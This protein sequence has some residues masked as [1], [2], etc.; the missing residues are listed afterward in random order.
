MN[1]LRLG[2]YQWLRYFKSQCWQYCLKLCID[3][4]SYIVHHSV[5]NSLS[6]ERH[7]T[8]NKFHAAAFL[9]KQT[10]GKL[11]KKNSQPFT[12]PEGSLPCA[13]QPATWPNPEPDGYSNTISMKFHY[14]MPLPSMPISYNWSLHITFSDQGFYTL[15]PHACYMLRP[16]HSPSLDNF[17]NLK[18]NNQPENSQISV[19]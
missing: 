8:N 15:Y 19:Q 5:Y 18:H 2:V 17:N 12:E 13:Q 14:N 1:V 16:S 6:A 11:V 7:L 3:F 4:L 9:E 10:V